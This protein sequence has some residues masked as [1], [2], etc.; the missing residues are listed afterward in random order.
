MKQLPSKKLLLA[1]A[2]I[3]G[4][5][6]LSSVVLAAEAPTPVA[7]G[8]P[9]HPTF[10]LLDSEGVNVLESEAP[11][12]TMRTCGAC[13]DAEFISTH[14][15]H[16]SLG[17]DDFG[18][19][20]GHLWDSSPG[21]FGNWNPLT[22]RY[23]STVGD[24]RL[25]L[26]TA[27]WVMQFGDRHA[28][29]GPAATSRDGTTV[30][31]ALSADD[32]NPETAILNAETA[33][34]QTWDWDTSGT[35]EMNC[36][37][38]HLVA[39]NNEARTQALQAG[40]F[41][42]A[43][44]ATLEG[45]GI[46]TR[47][48]EEWA[49]A[50]SAFQENGELD[51]EYV[52]VQD[53]SN[54]NCGQCHG[55]VHEDPNELLV[56]EAC[57]DTNWESYTTGQIHSPQRINNSGLN[58]SEKE[59]LSRSWDIHSERLVEC[60]DCHFS[61][62]NPI[63]Y[64]E[65]EDSRPEHL[66]FDPRRLDLGDYLYQPIHQFARGQSAQNTVAPELFDT[67]RRCESCHAAETTHDWLPYQERHFAALSCETCHIPQMYSSAIQSKDWTVLKQD[68]SARDECRGVTGPVDTSANTLVNG[69]QPVILQSESV[70]GT[71]SLSTYNLVS[72]WYWVYDDPPKPVRLIDLEAAWFD[73][74]AYAEDI[75]ALFDTNDDG[76]LQEQE[77][78]IDTDDKQALIATRLTELGLENP[79][80]VGEVQ[81]Y[82]INHN[83]TNGEWA[84]KDCQVCHSEDSLLTQDMQLAAQVPGGVMP[85]FIDS[86]NTIASGE[87]YQDENGALYYSPKPQ[88]DGLYILGHDSV[89]WVDWFGVLAVLGTMVGASVHGGLRIFASMRRP[90]LQPELKRVYMYGMYERLWHWLQ[91]F[92]I[93]ALTFTGFIIHKPEMFGIFSFRYVVQ[94]HNILAA[95]LIANAFL[96][97][98]YHLASGEIKQYIP[99]PRGFFGQAVEQTLYYIRGIFRGEDHPFEKSREKKLN[100]LQQV[101]YFGLLN[102][103]LPLQIITGALMWGAQ[104]WPEI[105]NALGGLPFLGPFHTL[106]AWSLVAF[107]IMHVYLTTTAG[108]TPQAGIKS[109]IM[110]WDDV[111]THSSASEEQN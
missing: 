13:H 25:D 3:Q 61:L 109:M 48:G 33:A 91:T 22:Y 97:L 84:I 57:D 92:T 21:Y 62:N 71:R 88:A 99:Q 11:V 36:F 101:T 73:G 72:S 40:Q 23:L 44:T 76:R 78:L 24:E 42:W 111:E 103:L 51:S 58:L 20:A 49:W 102:V 30:L 60:V 27:E 31:G 108:H 106:V 59:G 14:S 9:L 94:V 18:T 45:T 83:V 75:V 26:S 105:P 6:T 1:L 96:A 55:L 100:P 35:T 95:I 89:T 12:S 39:P 93:L 98:F 19:T 82:S 37:L 4:L 65:D 77:L 67:M 87:I 79:H 46:V 69:F 64:Q 15:F 10:A 86:A 70:D 85:E 104:R 63:F 28:G 32:G 16:T 17:L 80:I 68:T 81:P 41:A 66:T 8:T 29:G 50:R 5:A 56:Q 110:G 38:C 90:K 34:A 7:Q 107:I 53:P 2:L 47:E 74:D 43:S 54:A 52:T